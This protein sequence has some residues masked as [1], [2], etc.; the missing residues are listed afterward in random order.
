METNSIRV[1]EMNSSIITALIGI[2]PTIVVAIF[3]I[4]SNNQVIKVRI[5]ELEKKVEKHNQIV[6]RMYKAESDIKII[7]DEIGGKH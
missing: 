7:Q 2:I 1:T 6:E 4:V 5:D 3:S